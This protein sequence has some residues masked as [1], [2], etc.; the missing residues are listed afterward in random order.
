[1]RTFTKGFWFTQSSNSLLDV[2]VIVMG[3][4]QYQPIDGSHMSHWHFDTWQ[5]EFSSGLYQTKNEHNGK[6]AKMS[7]FYYFA[8]LSWEIIEEVGHIY[9][10]AMCQ[11]NILEVR[12]EPLKCTQEIIYISIH[13]VIIAFDKIQYG[14]RDLPNLVVEPKCY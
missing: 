7:Q 1:M 5:P 10:S 12:C 14:N 8:I 2:Y 11:M 13:C 3:D 9:G 6:K 4:S